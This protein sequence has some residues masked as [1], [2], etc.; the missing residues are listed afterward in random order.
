MLRNFLK[1]EK[2]SKKLKT[3]LAVII[4]L[5]IIASS[6]ITGCIIGFGTGKSPDYGLINQAWNA[7]YQ[8]YVDPSKLDTDI[9]SQGAVKGILDS[10]NDPY[11]AYLDPQNY[12][13]FESGLEGNFEGIGA[14]VQMNDNK[15]P[16]IVSTLD[17][18]PASQAG[19]KSGDIILAVDGKSTAGLNLTEVILMVRGK[20]G[21]QVT[22][23]V[24]HTGETTPVDISLTRAQINQSYVD[25]EM[26][27]DIAY[28][29]II[30]FTD[31]T[32]DEINLVL[33]SID[34]NST[35]GI[36]LDLR[37]NPGGLVTAVVDVA[38]HFIKSGV[39]ITLVDNKGNENSE[40]VNPNGVFTEL[41]M[42]VLVNQYSASG[43]E[44]LAGAL[45]DYQRATVA[46]VKTFG[47]GSYD[48]TI[49]LNDGSA[50]YLTVGRWLT[51][52]GRLIEGKGIEPDYVLTITGDEEIQWAIDYLNNQSSNT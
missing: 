16:E 51:P 9:Q 47:K 28:I 32:N 2:M 49:S 18:S 52:D 45:Q 15:Q 21:T 20:A 5:L 3:S 50:L 12:Q 35:A 39:I 23:T 22:L 25:W 42:V 37:S 11:S 17:N 6:F 41:P 36:I 4:I 27:G 13:L 19:I 8:E 24:L 29:H 43:A 44:V 46:G 31:T 48:V 33:E 1:E 7:I 14:V 38:S 26:K 10:I 34:L 30:E 40:S